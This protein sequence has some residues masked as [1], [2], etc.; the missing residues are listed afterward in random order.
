M[1]YPDTT[2]IE[3]ETSNIGLKLHTLCGDMAE[4]P[5]FKGSI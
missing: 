1:S 5:L 3:I 4:G 2:L